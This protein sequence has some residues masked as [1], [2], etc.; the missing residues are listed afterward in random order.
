MLSSSVIMSVLKGFLAITSLFHVP[1]LCDYSSDYYRGGR[2]I[3][4]GGLFS[5]Q[6]SASVCPEELDFSLHGC[7]CK[8]IDQRRTVQLECDGT[9]AEQVKILFDNARKLRR[10]VNSFSWKNS[11]TRFLTKPGLMDGVQLQELSI[12]DSSIQSIDHLVLHN[13]KELQ[14]LDLSGN[15][16]A[17]VPKLALRGLSGLRALTLDRNRIRSLGHT[18]FIQLKTLIELSIE[19]N[20][21]AEIERNTFSA[22]TNLEVLNLDRNNIRCLQEELF[23]NNRKLR[24]LSL[25]DNNMESLH[26][27]ALIGLQNSLEKLDLSDNQLQRVPEGINQLNRLTSLNLR[28]N[29]IVQF[30]ASTFGR[31]VSSSLTSID[32]SENNITRIPSKLSLPALTQLKMNKNLITHISTKDLQGM[33][34]LQYLYLRENLIEAIAPNAFDALP[35]LKWL[36]LGDNKLMQLMIET[37]AN[38]MDTLEILQLKGNPLI[39]DCSLKWIE[40]KWSI[41]EKVADTFETKCAHDPRG[42]GLPAGSSIDNL[43]RLHCDK[44]ERSSGSAYESALRGAATRCVSE[45]CFSSFLLVVALI[46]FNRG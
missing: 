37:F 6:L 9:D 20:E 42:M 39:C 32:L 30:N 31:N 23:K 3:R 2:L 41:T 5:N 38:V 25:P 7:S 24:E 40:Q 13:L 26:N 22:S 33:P 8:E 12:T 35:R 14:T 27:L 19:D 46:Y 44:H 1:V 4:G 11:K 36:Y 18:D 15:R 45:F 28:N 43:R 21:I 10:P 17:E 34:N 29:V 16:M